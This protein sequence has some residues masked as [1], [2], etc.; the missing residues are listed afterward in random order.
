MPF[1]K[2]KT[3]NKIK[4]FIQKKLAKRADLIISL[5]SQYEN[6]TDEDFKNKTEEFKKRYQD[7]ES[8][9]SLLNEAYAV[10]SVAA[11]KYTGMNPFKVQIMGAIVINGGNIAEMK[12]GE[13]KTLTAVLPAYLNALTGKGVHIVTVNE[14]LAGREA[15]GIIGE[16]FNHL[17]LSVGLNLRE[18]TPQQKRDAYNSDIMYTTNNEVG[19]DYLRDN[20]VVRKEDLVQRELNYAIIDEVDSVLIDEA[21][22]PLI[23]SGGAKDTQRLYEMANDFARFLSEEDYILDIKTKSIVLSE[24]G[25]RKAEQHFNI[26]NLYDIKNVTLLHNISNALKA[27]F[28]MQRDVDYVV[29]DNQVI[30][31]DPFTGRLM[32]GRQ[33][34]EGLHQALEAKEHVEIKKET[35]TLATITFQNFFRMYNKLSGMTGTAKTEEEE[36][37]N[38]YNM[39]VIEIPTNAPVIRIDANDKIFATKEAKFKAL[40]ADVKE[41]HQKGQPILIGTIAIETSELVSKMLK[42]EGI[43]HNLLNAKEHEREAEIV[44]H[45][46]EKGAVTI[47]T[48]MAGRGTDIKLGEGVVELGG[49]AVI[50]TE[51]HESRRI[52]N[53]LR[54]RSGRQGDPGYSCFYISAED[55]LMARFGSERFKTLISRVLIAQGGTTDDSLDFGIFSSSILRAQKQIEGDN[56]DQRKTVLQ[57]DEVM[58]KQREVIYAQRREILFRESIEDTIYGIIDET[59]AKKVDDHTII[60]KTA[61]VESKELLKDLDGSFFVR[62]YIDIDDCTGTVEEVIQKLQKRAHEHIELLKEKVPNEVIQEA[63]KSVMLRIVDTYWM[64][65]IDVMSDLRQAVALQSY[66]QQNPLREYQVQGFNLFNEMTSNIQKETASFILHLV[67]AQARENSEREQVMKATGT[68]RS[69]QGDRPKRN[70]ATLPKKEKIGRNAPCPCGAKWPDGTPKKYKDCHGKN[71]K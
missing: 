43:P 14:Y 35:T 64:Q 47:A 10:A 7:G 4:G 21:R 29:Q 28:T 15:N 62:N 25:I 63:F 23:I 55:D 2:H 6:F 40:V 48:N 69:D 13:G 16:L 53:Q 59:V 66:A 58:R 24:Q 70:P 27:N 1:V 65:H 36:F 61:T 50:G 8:L 68:N 19:F 46:G 18:L 33:F 38:I 45:A 37:I 52:D 5:E 44:L 42:K 34:T 60:G 3:D 54:G 56:F 57:Y 12:T 22:T 49:L 20:M 71:A 30:I 41:R 11:K 39:R 67:P 31:V 26:D 32:I 17:G 9:D 51:R